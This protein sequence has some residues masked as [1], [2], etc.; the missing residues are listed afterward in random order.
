M[1]SSFVCF[2]IRGSMFAHVFHGPICIPVCCVVCICS[3][4]I[5]L[6]LYI[7]IDVAKLA[8][9]CNFDYADLGSKKAS[10]RIMQ[11]QLPQHVLTSF[12]W[13]RVNIVRVHPAIVERRPDDA[14]RKGNRCL[15]YRKHQVFACWHRHCCHADLPRSAGTVSG[16][17]C[18]RS[19]EAMGFTGRSGSW[20]TP[21]FCHMC[22]CIRRWEKMH[23][24]MY[25]SIDQ[26]NLI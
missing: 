25:L 1:D 10:E 2:K 24:Y 17:S 8:L 14:F 13:S 6:L 22:V 3:S 19:G 5:F 11:R 12:L 4:I 21:L 7:G 15:Q 23:L 9:A 20:P 16:D 26:S 18:L